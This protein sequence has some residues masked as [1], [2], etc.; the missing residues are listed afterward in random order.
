MLHDAKSELC[1]KL[2]VV[3]I[4]PWKFLIA[5]ISVTKDATT[6]KKYFFRVT[7]SGESIGIYS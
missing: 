5:Y 2:L 6:M 7:K 4:F 1:Q 3:D